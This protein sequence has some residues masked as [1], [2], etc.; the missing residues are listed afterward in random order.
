MAKRRKKSWLLRTFN[1]WDLVLISAIVF[2]GAYI[3]FVFGLEGLYEN[4]AVGIFSAL[5][6]GL[7]VNLI[8][9]KTKK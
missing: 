3:Y 2:S 5:F 9:K 4:I 6:V 8:A 7:I 1:I